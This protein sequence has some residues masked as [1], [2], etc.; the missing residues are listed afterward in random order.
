MA[1]DGGAAR[2]IAAAVLTTLQGALHRA[3]PGAFM[4]ELADILAATQPA[5]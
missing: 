3:E 5:R 1:S 2:D 4:P